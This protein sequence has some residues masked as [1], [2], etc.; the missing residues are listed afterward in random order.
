[1]VVV[2]ERKENV[3]F[4]WVFDVGGVRMYFIRKWINLVM[5]QR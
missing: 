4:I 5:Y 2:G 3:M 1:M